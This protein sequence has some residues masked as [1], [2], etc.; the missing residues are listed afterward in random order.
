MALVITFTPQD[1][2]SFNDDIYYTVTS[3][4][5]ADPITYPDFKFI[6]DVYIGGVMVARLKKIPLPSN[7]VGVF[8]IGQIVR[9]YAA[10]VF[11]PTFGQIVMQSLGD[12]LFN[13][14]VQMKFGEEYSN[15]DF[16]NVTVDSIR[17]Y[18]NNYN[19][20]G[21]FPNT[22]LSLFANKVASNRSTTGQAMLSQRFNLIPYFPIA[23]APTIS[24]TVTPSG[25]GIIY[26]TSFSPAQYDMTILNFAPANLNALQAGTITAGTNYY[27][28]AIGSQTYRFYVIC[29]PIYTPVMIHFL[30]KFGGFESKS[31]NKVSRYNVDINKTTYGKY[32]Y[33]IKDDGTVQNATT[34]KV[35]NE[36]TSVYSS[37]YTENKVFNT[38]FLTD[39]DYSWLED[40]A[41]SPMIYL[42]EPNG[43]FFPILIKDSNYEIRKNINDE[44]TNLTINVQY[45]QTLNAQYR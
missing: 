5:T 21:G 26:S 6:G 10:T 14:E 28:V 40:L 16:L 31:F 11:D 17:V 2:C 23:A 20:R 13:L 30:N 12:T 32:P 9:S 41:L 36:F 43:D 33:T 44:L 3:D 39:A 4:K 1:L 18:F 45:G 22:S 34:N 15:T 29:E 35:Y 19:G 24:V 7:G 25:G 37:Q 27:D 38:D 42:E 8:N